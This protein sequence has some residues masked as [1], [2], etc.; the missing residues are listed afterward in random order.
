[1]TGYHPANLGFLDLSFETSAR[2]QPKLQVHGQGASVSREV[3]CLFSSQPASVP[4]HYAN[5]PHKQS[6]TNANSQFLLDELAAEF[7]VERTMSALTDR[8][9]I[10]RLPPVHRR[11]AVVD[12]WRRIQNRSRRVICGDRSPHFR[13]R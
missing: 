2:H 3:E 5:K 6:Y 8:R 11:Q 7:H 12:R 1:V 4:N 10:G 13:I 9:R